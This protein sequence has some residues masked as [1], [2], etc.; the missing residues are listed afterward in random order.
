MT[1]SYQPPQSPT[2][3]NSADLSMDSSTSEA[4]MPSRM[5][6]Q[7]LNRQTDRNKERRQS[8]EPWDIPHLCFTGN[9]EELGPFS[10]AIKDYLPLVSSNFASEKCKINWVACHFCYDSSRAATTT[11]QPL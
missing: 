3:S 11:T 5:L 2:T 6:E 8:I 4:N 9:P 1:N 10:Y 7:F